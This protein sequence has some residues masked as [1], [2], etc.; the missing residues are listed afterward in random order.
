MPRRAAVTT[1]E[2]ATVTLRRTTTMEECPRSSVDTMGDLGSQKRA[3][4]APPKPCKPGIRS[5]TK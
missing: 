4:K 1:E 2:R 5:A 3:K